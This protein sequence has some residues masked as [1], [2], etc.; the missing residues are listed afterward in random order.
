MMGTRSRFSTASVFAFAFPRN[1]RAF[2]LSTSLDPSLPLP[3]ARLWLL[4]QGRVRYCLKPVPLTRS[5][6]VKPLRCSKTCLIGVLHWGVLPGPSEPVMS[7]NVVAA[8]HTASY[9]PHF[10]WT[11]GPPGRQY[12]RNNPWDSCSVKG[13][14]SSHMLNQCVNTTWSSVNIFTQI[15]EANF[16]CHDE[17]VATVDTCKRQFTE[18]VWTNFPLF[19]RESG[20][21][22]LRSRSP[23]VASPEEYKKLYS[24]WEMTS[25]HF[26]FFWRMLVDS[27]YTIM[28]QCTDAWGIL[29]VFYVKVDL[30][31]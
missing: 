6:C 13:K 24:H 11:K 18:A 9:F 2:G 16:L 15:F 20:P 19:V 30:K 8:R 14:H 10:V 22:T 3:F 29:H 21:R 25:A 23:V 27:A 1:Q 28:R 17:G 5:S 4:C 12:W 31:F 7:S 26:P